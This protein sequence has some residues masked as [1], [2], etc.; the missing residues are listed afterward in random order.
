MESWPAHRE[1]HRSRI[2]CENEPVI[3]VPGRRYGCQADPHEVE[4]YVARWVRSGKYFSLKILVCQYP[5]AHGPSST[6]A[7]FSM[8]I[9]LCL[10]ET[11]GSL[12][13]LS[14]RG[15]KLR[16]ESRVHAW[17]LVETVGNVAVVVSRANLKLVAQ[18]GRC[19][20]RG[21]FF[22]A[23]Q[24]RCPVDCIRNSPYSQRS[25]SSVRFRRS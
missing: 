19:D 4:P 13:R 25:S 7:S 2:V 11:C 22:K 20:Q 14:C 5:M 24:A 15:Q 6:R 16:Y 10:R 3:S 9:S 17:I 12:S 1:S 21:G 8:E 23:D 18:W